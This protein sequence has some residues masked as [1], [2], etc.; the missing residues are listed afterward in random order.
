MRILMF[1]NSFTYFND[2]P[3]ML[4]DL[5][6]AEVK[7]VTKGGAKLS[8][9]RDP[10]RELGR[11]AEEALRSGQWD[12][13]VLQDQSSRPV[14][15]RDS[16]LRDV[17]ILGRK[18]RSVGARPLLFAT[19]PYRPGAAQYYKTGLDYERLGEGLADSYKAAG[20]KEHMPVAEAGSRFIRLWQS[21]DPSE[22]EGLYAE[23]GS[24]PGLRG[25][26]IAAECIAE[27]IKADLAARK[28][29]EENG[30]SPGTEGLRGRESL[31][32]EME[33]YDYSRPTG[34]S[35]RDTD[36]RIRI[37]HMY[38]VLR[39]HSDSEHP[40]TTNQIR[41][42][43]EA[44]HGI[45][46][47][48]TTVPGDIE[49]LKAAG[50]NIVGRRARQNKYYLAEGEFELPELKILIDAVESSRF[51]TEKKSRELIGKL[52][53]LTSEQ[54]AKKLRRHIYTTGRV[55][56]MNEKCWY[57][58]DAFNEAINEGRRV[59]FYYTDIDGRKRVVLR[60]HGRPYIISPYTLLWNGDFY[61]LL[62]YDHN[63]G[64]MR[65][66]RVDRI[67]DRPEILKEAAD[68]VPEG[69]DLGRYTRE[70]F[71]MFDNEELQEVDLLCSYEVM[72]GVVDQFGM[73]IKIKRAGTGWFGLRVTVCTSATFYA[74]VF[75]WAGRI[76]IAGPEKAR[77]EYR[78]MALKA[79]EEQ[80]SWNQT[81]DK[82]NGLSGR[83]E[84]SH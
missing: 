1:G 62:G 23:D 18:I 47:H 80:T 20:E 10:G 53:S 24:H 17:H 67:A 59:S 2:M 54:N 32:A 35:V 36:I 8:E 28:D 61:Y 46:M 52:A 29:E 13:V 9:F 73:D 12:Y 39:K 37:L 68:P 50:F 21:G 42:L 65:T 27:V 71:R 49:V 38:Q 25:S 69:F 70:V 40:L 76:R 26:R 5:L 15:F 3:S 66:Y 48:R 74:W 51:I 16:F 11:E 60:N 33:Y 7:A 31:P 81:G 41:A 63:K 56:S 55:R 72:K 45:T 6:D 14:R 84:E 4:A 22:K 79:L 78:Q 34:V 58:I 19:W 57:I 43:M 82:T 83:T 30:G 64:E 77:E 44:E 75:Q